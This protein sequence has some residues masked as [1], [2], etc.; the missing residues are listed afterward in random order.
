MDVPTAAVTDSM[1]IEWRIDFFDAI[2]DL[3]QVLAAAE[4]LRTLA[5][6]IPLILTRRAVHEGCEPIPPDEEHVVDLYATSCASGDIDAV[7]YE[8]S[9]PEHHRSWV[10]AVSQAFGVRMIVYSHDSAATPPVETMLNSLL[11]AERAGVDV[12]KLAV[13][14]R[15]PSDVLRLLEAT[16]LAS[17]ALDMQK[18]IP[19]ARHLGCRTPRTECGAL[20]NTFDFLLRSNIVQT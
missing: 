5:G 15:E 2:A 12:A 1:L 17:E 3:S 4:A 9:Q 6:S 13:M 14:P 18:H 16:L 8:L 10:Q 11:R 20:Q 7:N 19:C